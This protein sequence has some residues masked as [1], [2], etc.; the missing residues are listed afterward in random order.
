MCVS[1]V[2]RQTSSKDFH[3]ENNL[4]EEAP[5]FGAFLPSVGEH[6]SPAWRVIITFTILLCV[7]ADNPG[8]SPCESD[9]ALLLESLSSVFLMTLSNTSFLKY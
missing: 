3:T 6:S 8:G 4:I 9:K 7:K 1:A 2:P 5:T